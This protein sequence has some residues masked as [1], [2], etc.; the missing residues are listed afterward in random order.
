MTTSAPTSSSSTTPDRRRLR[1]P[2][3]GSEPTLSLASNLWPR[4][5]GYVFVCPSYP[6]CDSFVRCHAGTQEPLGTLAAPRLRR[7]RGE[8]HEA[9]DPLWNEPGTKFGRDFA[10]QVAGQVLGIDDFHIGYLDEAGCRELIARIDEIDDAL[11][12]TYDSLQSPT[13]TVGEAVMELLCEIFG[14]GSTGASRHV[15]IADLAKF[16]GVADQAKSAGLLRL[17]PST[18]RAFLSAHGAILL[19]QFNR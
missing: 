12:A 8:A 17:E 4:A 1:C 15:S 18:G 14:V 13:A 16:P 9:F 7:L 5:T 11:S 3:C 19:T 2:N 6:G 10:Y